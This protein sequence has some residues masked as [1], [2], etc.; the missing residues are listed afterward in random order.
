MNTQLNN[1]P[2]ALFEESTAG[3]VLRIVLAIVIMAAG[4][5]I[6]TQKTPASAFSQL[7]S[8]SDTKHLRIGVID[9]PEW[10]VLEFVRQE[11]AHLHLELVRYPDDFSIRRALHDHEVD[12]ASFESGVSVT[13]VAE[14]PAA[15]RSSAGLTVTLPLAFYSKKLKSLGDLAPSARVVISTDPEAE[16]RALL[17]LHHFGF[18]EFNAALGPAVRLGDVEKNPHNLEILRRPSA[19]L[20]NA[21]SHAELVALEYQAAKT[22]GLAPA[23]NGLAM[24][25]GFSPFA[26]VLTIQTQER[27]RLTPQLDEFWQAYHSSSVKKFIR[28][29]FED[30]VRRP[31]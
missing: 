5:A 1:D 27:V 15:E 23:R 3:A 22:A 29:N 14:N 19:E 12:A 10:E 2:P 4:I 6:L 25:D 31:W 16:G 20:I 30:S 24:E 18:I 28:V 11:N 17:L 13:T 26:Q 9:G 7:I 8:E 21:L